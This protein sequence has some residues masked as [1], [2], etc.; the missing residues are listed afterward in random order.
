M[1]AFLLRRRRRPR[2]SG[3]G[4]D[5]GAQTR[6]GNPVSERDGTLGVAG[7]AR[8]LR[9]SLLVAERGQELTDGF[10]F[11][12]VDFGKWLGMHGGWDESERAG[13]CASRHDVAKQGGEW[14]RP[15]PGRTPRSWH[16]WGHE[17]PCSEH[18]HET[19]SISDRKPVRPPGSGNPG[20]G[21]G[22]GDSEGLINLARSTYNIGCSGPLST[23]SD[24]LGADFSRSAPLLPGSSGPGAISKVFPC[25]LIGLEEGRRA[26]PP[27]G[28]TF[29][30]VRTRSIAR[31]T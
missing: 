22:G 3:L 14:N 9:L 26:G 17:W 28:V 27:A 30:W 8:G 16:L 23:D 15:D 19:A 12:R 1:S 31:S 24:G 11:R 20:A 13:N 4:R 7:R 6:P 5:S 18:P 25:G 29:S 2:R 10:Q 21:R